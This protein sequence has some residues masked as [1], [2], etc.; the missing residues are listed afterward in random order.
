MSFAIKK[1]G[2]ICIVDVEGQLIVGNRQELKQKVLD[3]LER[4]ERK[5]LVDF[6]Q[7]GYIDSSGL[8]V[9]VSLSKKIREAY[10]EHVERVFGLAGLSAK[11]A[12]QAAADVMRIE[13][14]LAKVSKTLVERRDPKGLY[15]K[16]ERAQLAKIAPD[17]P[18]DAYFKALGRPDLT[19]VNLTSVPF[20][21]GMNKLLKSTKPAAWQSYLA[22]H[23]VRSS[24]MTLPKAFVDEA[25]T[26]TSTLSGQKQL[27]PRWRRCVRATDQALGELVAQ[28]YIRANFPG[29]SKQAAE[30]MVSTDANVELVLTLDPIPSVPAGTGA[31]PTSPTGASRTS[32]RNVAPSPSS[33]AGAS[34]AAP[35]VSARPAPSGKTGVT[36]DKD[37]PWKTH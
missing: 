17:F 35:V 33:V 8:G 23:V 31:A 24:A 4:G 7:T 27:P 3:E 5:F 10:V 36:L 25:F 34:S 9:L 37:D 26:M 18:W 15:N 14:E 12:K 16:T 20:F 6:S 2:D 32:Q 19:E 22:W 1:Q 28:P 30:R 29:E 11:A 21:E 13:T